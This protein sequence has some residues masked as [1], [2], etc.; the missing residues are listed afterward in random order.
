VRYAF[1]LLAALAASVATASSPSLGSVTPRGGQRGTELTLSFNG[2]RLA[3][4]KEI[5]FYSPGMTVN[6][7]KP[8]NDNQVQ[9]TVKIAADCRL[10]EHVVRVRTATGLSEMRTFWVG[11]LPPLDEKE[12]NS[13][14][15]APQKI[16]LNVTVLGVVDNED[17][18][19]YAFEAKKGQRVS[20]EVEGMRLAN[21]FFD[22]YVAILDGKRFELAACDDQPLLKQDAFCSVVIPADGTYYVQVRESAYGGNGA[23]QYRL[24]VGNFPRPTALVPAGGKL[25][26]EVEVRFLG[27]PTGEMRQKVKLPTAPDERFAVHVQDATGVSPSGMPFRLVEFGNALEVE[28]NDIPQQATKAGEL[29]IALN[30]VV[31]KP[32]DTDFFRITAKKGQV[33]DVHCYAR[34]LGSALDPVLVIH[35]LNGGGIVG[36]DDAVGPD[37]YFRWTVPADQDYL[38]SVKDHLGKG[39]P[40]YFYRVEFQPIKAAV[41]VSIP[42]AAQYSQER[43][44]LVIHRGNRMAQLINAARRDVGGDLTFVPD[45]LPAGVKV[46]CENMPA[47]LDLMPVVFEADAAAPVA[48]ALSNFAVK[49]VDP[50]VSL[51]SGFYQMAE[52]VINQPGQSI[53]VK[54]EV[55]KQAIAVADEVPFSINIVEPKAPLVH[56]GSMN[57]KIVATRKPGFTAPITIVPLYNPPGVGSASSVVIP[58]NQTETLLPMNA[59]GGAPPKK[60]RTAVLGTA[61]VGNGPVWVSSQLATIEIAPPFVTFAME[62]AAC[63]QGKQTELFVKIQHATPFEG[64]AKVNLVGLPAKVTTTEQTITKDT[65]EIAFKLTVDKASPAGQHNGL[66]CQVVVPFAGETVLHN[67][68]GT[69]LR[70][71]VPLPPKP[72]EP[73][74]PV[75]AAPPPMPMPN[76]PPPKRLS[77][78][79]MLRLEQEE[80]EKAA[81]GG[82]PAPP[83]K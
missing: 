52:Y 64:S 29:P 9:A 5:V 14:F 11:N 41:T 19:Y 65:K 68:G 48:G 56:N 15:A 77:R 46:V 59:N 34:R 25:G 10:G 69:Q 16:N 31:E 38:V 81:K 61:T 55:N 27:D 70:I 47:N 75:V 23:C 22:P 54:G 12:P 44:P 35:D 1:T 17:V 58:E 32:N 67:V 50:K 73:A 21:T 20:V 66:F 60:W 33:F 18:D 71:D 6:Q 42:K 80:R 76:Q 82:T 43:Q 26:D 83:K 45:G 13:D 62:R 24:H 2:A 78:L 72:N 28:P 63:E 51:T 74:K 40:G 79:E 36:N 57:L 4:A 53:Y 8:V 49:H 30:G 7:L 39:A 37:S 3:D